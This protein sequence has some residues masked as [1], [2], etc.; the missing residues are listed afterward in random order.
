MN[1][2]REFLLLWLRG[3]G[4]FFLFGTMAVSFLEWKF[5]IESFRFMVFGFILIATA[6]YLK[7]MK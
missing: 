5:D 2:E 3:A 7:E 1:R 6:G 4:I